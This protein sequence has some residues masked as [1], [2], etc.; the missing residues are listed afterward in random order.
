MA[1]ANYNIK[2]SYKSI[3]KHYLYVNLP[4]FKRDETRAA[5]SYNGESR[6]QIFAWKMTW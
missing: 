1:K 3:G 5:N 6:M 2:I 4:F